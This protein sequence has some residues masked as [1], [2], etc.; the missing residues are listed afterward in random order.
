MRNPRVPVVLLGGLNVMRPLGIAGIPVILATSEPDS[1]AAASRYC[2]GTIPLPRFSNRLAVVE[3][4]VRAG[5][6]LAAEHGAPL[7]LFCDNDDRLGLVQDHRASL[8]PHF[9]LLV[10]RPAL[11][12][13]LLDKALFQTLAERHGLP[14][15]RRIEWR[16]LAS[17]SG[18]VLIKPKVKSAWDGSAVREQLFRGAGKARLFESGADAARDPLVAQ[19]APKLQCQEYIPGG[20]DT[21]W[22]FHGFAAA[23]GEVLEWFVGRKIRAYP[24]L[25]GDSSY[26]QLARDGALVALGRDLARRLRLA[27]VFTMDFKRHPQ[28]GRFHL[29]EI[30]ARFNPWHYVG[31]MN[32]VNLPRTAYEYLLRGERPVR[33]EAQT[34]WRW[35]AL[36]YD[37]RAYREL[38]AQGR[39]G[40]AAWLWSLLQAPT[41]YERFA[42]ND[43][44]PLLRHWAARVWRTASL[45]R[46]A[47]PAGA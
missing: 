28:S 43:P 47:G 45:P 9:A 29:L 16:A 36:R 40:A 25:I 21:I 17:E 42:W 33:H 8:G 12:D 38:K 34:R 22:S 11:A 41:V 7:P 39:L 23:D 2:A 3:A 6:R 46:R 30:S 24:A 27:G 18:P 14:V 20:D 32:G 10:N 5:R 4:L 44:M 19:L 26:L 31:A 37:R 15:P 13:A 35:L 1:E